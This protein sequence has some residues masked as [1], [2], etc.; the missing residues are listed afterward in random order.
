MRGE[1]EGRGEKEVRGERSN[2]EKE[3][4]DVSGHKTSIVPVATMSM[5]RKRN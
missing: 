1:K 3:R 4:G 5:R 2:R